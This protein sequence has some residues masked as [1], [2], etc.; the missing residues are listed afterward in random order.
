M[1][2][3]IKNVLPISGDGKTACDIA[4][5]DGVIKKIGTDFTGFAP[6]ETIDGGGRIA[7][8]ALINSH[9]HMYMSVLR[10]AADDMPFMQWLFEGVM[11]RED[12]MNCE[13]AYWGALLSCA[14]MI[15]R[16]CSTFNDM[17]LFP[18]ASARAA[19]KA[20]MRAVENRAVTG[21]EGGERR[22]K[23]MLGEIE[24]FKGC[25]NVHFMIAPHAIYT[26]S[27][28]YLM[29]LADIA[30][31]LGLPVHI[32]L[33]ESVAEVNDCLRDH[34]C[35][36]VEYLVNMGFFK[37]KTL[38]AHCVQLTET[39]I[40]L[41]AEHGVSVAANPKSN[42][43]LG[44]G[45]APVYQLD[46]AGVNVCIGTDSAASNNS[47]NMFA[48]MNYTAL[49]HKGT[50]G[51]PTVIP[52]RKAFEMATVNG[53]KA[54][55]I[56][57][58]GRLEEGWKADIVLLDTDVPQMMPIRDDPYAAVVYSCDGSETDT[59]IIDGKPVYLHKQFTTIDTEELYYN[60]KKICE[61]I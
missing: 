23:E 49:L 5:S 31:E 22:I 1:D 8:P 2:L 3:L 42:L 20:G 7:M 55:C 36:P 38:A 46:K 18:G 6:D 40:L 39:D 54:L 12:K 34:G 51:D 13:Q 58:L 56:D 26:C 53:A 24:E 48:E 57:R 10:N 30:E 14:E 47:L 44:N 35:T 21:P 45:I 4:V 59:V 33:S 11:P 27:Q 61:V 9:T 28:E 52:A 16:G 60:I 25:A 43:K 29:K 19:M 17:H 37:N 32:H 15:R 41:L 50:N